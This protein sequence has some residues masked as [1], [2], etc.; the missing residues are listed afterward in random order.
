MFGREV[1]EV[2]RV[3]CYGGTPPIHGLVEPV[4][5]VNDRLNGFLPRLQSQS[6]GW[7]WASIVVP[8]QSAL[9]Q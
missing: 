9:G 7:R 5:W 8:C 2:C 3:G 1:Q 4:R 6:C